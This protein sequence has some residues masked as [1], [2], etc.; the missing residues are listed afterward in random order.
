MRNK[1]YITL[2][3]SL[4]LALLLL[5]AMGYGALLAHKNG[6]AVIDQVAGCVAMSVVVDDSLTAA[7]I[8]TLEKNITACAEVDSV[9][10]VN[11]VQASKEFSA[12]IGVEPAMGI[13]LPRSFD[14]Y[15]R[16]GSTV[17][18]RLIAR[19]AAQKGVKDVVCDPLLASSREK[20]ID[21]ITMIAQSIAGAVALAVV[22][23]LYIIVGAWV[24][25]NIGAG[26]VV[27]RALMAGVGAGMLA[28]VAIVAMDEY[29]MS[30]DGGLSLGSE[31]SLVV[32]SS[33]VIAGSVVAVLF[34]YMSIKS[35]K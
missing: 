26:A 2:I 16:G 24:R 22:V 11:S 15:Y 23:M 28:G 14:V 7:E 8:S 9:V 17:A 1:G 12:A 34:S 3:V 13:T 6:R 29:L 21:R 5:G 31:L 10:F 18:G 4:W 35:Q 32:G 25:R 30:L 33:V 27:T 20:L 19:F